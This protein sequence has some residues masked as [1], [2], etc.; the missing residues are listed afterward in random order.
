MIR[1]AKPQQNI[2]E[3]VP[4]KDQNKAYWRGERSRFTN[5]MIEF[6]IML[7]RQVLLLLRLTSGLPCAATLGKGGERRPF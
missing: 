7:V 4:R 6:A 2:I 3:S 1:Q 5:N